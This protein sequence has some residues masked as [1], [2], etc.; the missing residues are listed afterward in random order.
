LIS[1]E[2]FVCE[3]ARNAKEVLRG[4]SHNPDYSGLLSLTEMAAMAKAR[5]IEPRAVRRPEYRFWNS[6]QVETLLKEAK[7]LKC[8]EEANTP[9]VKVYGTC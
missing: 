6:E 3:L 4:E 5:W 1:R 2:V 7:K 8:V 9:D